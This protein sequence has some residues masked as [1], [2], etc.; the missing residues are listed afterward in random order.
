MTTVKFIKEM[1][2]GLS[3]DAEVHVYAMLNRQHVV[4]KIGEKGASLPI[5]Y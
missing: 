1:I 3:D 5:E 2:E 4:L